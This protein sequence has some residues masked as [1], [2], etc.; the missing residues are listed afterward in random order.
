M[1][2]P[3]DL[4]GK[5]IGIEGR[6]GYSHLGALAVLATAGLT[7]KDVKYIKTPAAGARSLPAQGQGR[8]RGHSRRA[9]SRRQ[10]EQAQ[11]QQADGLVEGH[12]ELL[13]RG[14]HRAVVQEINSNKDAYVRFAM[15]MMQSNRSIYKDK[16]GYLKSANKWVRPVYKK[17]PESHVENV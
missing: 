4:K 7:D 1:K 15:A 6:G 13:L 9:G 8:R 2:K 3:A 12:A 17:N 11:L 10:E 14:V 5:T 16:A